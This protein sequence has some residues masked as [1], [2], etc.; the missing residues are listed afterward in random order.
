MPRI[1]RVV[2]EGYPHHITQRGNYRQKIF[3]IDADMEKYLILIGAESKRYELKVLAYCLM[4]NHIHF[5]VLPENNDSMGKAFKYVNMKYSQYYNKKIGS[6]GHLF[7]GRFFSSVMD[8]RYLIACARYIERN[9]VRAKMVRMPCDYKWSSAR[10]HCGMDGQDIFGV[11]GLFNYADYPQKDWKKFIEEPDNI[12]E[13]K[14]IRDQTRRGRPLG[15]NIFIKKLEKNLG[16]F[17]MLRPRGRPKKNK[18]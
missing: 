15:E 7:Q 3:S 10:M 6:S 18:N 14:N 12:G 16:R 17:L 1:A 5:I 8:E 13:I 11:K 4:P 2:A 9:P